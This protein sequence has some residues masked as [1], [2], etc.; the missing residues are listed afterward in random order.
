MKSLIE[1]AV[2]LG[3]NPH[4]HV[5][6]SGECFYKEHEFSETPIYVFSDDNHKFY[7][8]QKDE[9]SKF[10]YIK[11][12]YDF[13]RGWSLTK[14]QVKKYAEKF[15][16]KLEVLGIDLYVSDYVFENRNTKTVREKEYAA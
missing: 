3:L 11:D 10:I 5:T 12:I 1:I 2:L 9:N 14:T 4:N 6:R 7:H 15:E 13:A 8:L 16:G